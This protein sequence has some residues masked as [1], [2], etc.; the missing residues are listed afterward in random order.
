M[1]LKLTTAAVRRV[2]MRSI[3]KPLLVLVTLL[4]SQCTSGPSPVQQAS[5]ADACK[6]LFSKPIER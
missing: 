3:G 6:A 4:L 1:K 2:A 5:H